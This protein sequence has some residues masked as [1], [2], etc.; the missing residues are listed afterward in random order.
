MI[1]YGFYYCFI[2]LKEYDVLR[3]VKM[4]QKLTENLHGGMIVTSVVA[5]METYNVCEK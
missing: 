3:L 5:F 1:L 2:L 4:V